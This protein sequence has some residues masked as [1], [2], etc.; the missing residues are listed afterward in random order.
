VNLTD[1]YKDT[2]LDIAI[3]NQFSALIPIL[4]DHG[5]DV[6]A[7]DQNLTRPLTYARRMDDGKWVKYLKDH[8]AHD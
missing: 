1:A 3:G 7:I 6:N 4:V 8:G 5:A 2:I